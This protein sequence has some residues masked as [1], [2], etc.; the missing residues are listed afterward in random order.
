M[1]W[2]DELYKVYEYNCGKTD[3]E[4]M[5]L[6]VSH[7]TAN[8]QIELT[9]D[10]KGNFIS[11]RTVDKSEA[12]TIIPDTGK[13]KTGKTPPPYPLAE[14][15]KYI[16]GDYNTYKPE[17]VKDNSD[18]FKAYT[19]QLNEWKESN[20]SHKA[21]NAIY[22]YVSK[23]T[24][25]SDCIKSGVLQIDEETGK[26]A[27][28]QKIGTVA[29]KAFVRFVVLYDDITLE[30]MTWKDKSLYDNFI[31]FNS[32]NLGN[33]QLCYAL[34]KELP[35][36]YVH[37]YQIIKR[38]ARA[39]II[40]SNDDKDFTF[41]GRFRNKEEAI[42]VSYDFSQKM[43]NALK[44]L[45]ARQ[46]MNFGSLTVVMWASQMQPLP[47]IRKNINDDFEANSFP[48]EDAAPQ[49]GIQFSE[50]LEK[51]IWGYKKEFKADTKVMV[52]GLDAATTGRLSIAMYTELAGSDFMNNIEAW[53]K[54]SA[55]MRYNVKLNASMENSFSIYEI[56]K[57]AFGPER[58]GN[59]EAPDTLNETVLRLIPCVIEGRKLPK[60]I[61]NSLYNRAS[62]P[63]AFEKSY[64][65]RSVLEAA[66]GMLRF[67]LKGES[68][69]AYDKNETDRSYLYGCL[70]AIADKTESDT[71]EKGETRITNA[72]R[73][74]NVFSSRPY[75]TWK[76]IEERL[77]PYLDKL[78]NYR[79]VY[80]KRVQEIMDKMDLKTFEDNS[81]LEPAYLLGYHHYTSYMYTKNAENNEEE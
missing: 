37:P 5:L 25:I 16:A 77:Q 70:L 81:K 65:H 42:S 68:P 50:I 2:T 12:E 59:L 28:K 54:N 62:A 4:P 9:I 48:D 3:I 39:K 53:H 22:E 14:T 56:A 7:S 23:S 64:N 69:M 52:L 24:V 60:D 44:W 18:F 35:V 11:A 26:L 31:N 58:N 17:N 71:F 34:G 27:N 80:E 55:C 47:D 46:G 61:L 6:P 29:E 73:Y 43:H 51:C 72:K 38:H 74:W 32:E 63:L 1:G 79:T 40:S 20:Y 66:C 76:I 57:C 67:D 30:N 45:I 41:R 15:L 75:Q 19:N 49:T 33:K 36:T 78:G 21:V 10:E 13:A 8:A